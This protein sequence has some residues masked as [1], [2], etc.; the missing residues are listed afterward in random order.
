M[1]TEQE[2]KT[3]LK[4]WILKKS[5]K[6]KE[7][8]LTDQTPLFEKRIITSLQVMELI[9]EIEKIRGSKFNLKSIKPGAFGSIDNIYSSFFGS[10]S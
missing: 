1:K 3:L 7:S 8:D 6:I 9:L 10:A 5:T 2:V 4:Q